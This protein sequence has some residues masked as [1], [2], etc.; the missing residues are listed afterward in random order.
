MTESYAA[1]HTKYPQSLQ[2]SFSI[3][4]KELANCCF[5][6]FINDSFVY[7]LDSYLRV[8][9]LFPQKS[10]ACGEVGNYVQGISSEINQKEGTRGALF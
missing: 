10:K 3:H 5:L 4:W 8:V 6:S 1:L 2:L 7:V 9:F